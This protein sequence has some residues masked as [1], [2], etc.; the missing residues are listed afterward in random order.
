MRTYLLRNIHNHSEKS[1]LNK[2]ASSAVGPI[3]FNLSPLSTMINCI[4]PVFLSVLLFFSPK[5]GAH[6]LQQEDD[7][8]SCTDEA[9]QFAPVPESA[10]GVNVSASEIGYVTE[11]LGDGAYGKAH[12]RYATY[13]TA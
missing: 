10:L 9:L 4:F 3:R 5:I 1:L 12:L 6:D 2:P 13:Q 8:C 7:S 11:S